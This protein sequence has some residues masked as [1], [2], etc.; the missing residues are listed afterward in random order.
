MVRLA[1]E[2][3]SGVGGLPPSLRDPGRS[4]CLLYHPLDPGGERDHMLYTIRH[5]ILLARKLWS[6]RRTFAVFRAYSSIV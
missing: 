2:G 3:V 6:I 4:P 5:K 1:G